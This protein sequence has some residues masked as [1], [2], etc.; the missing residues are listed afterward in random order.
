M[1][2]S[3]ITRAYGHQD[4]PDPLSNALRPVTGDRLY[5]HRPASR[6]VTSLRF[7][8]T[9]GRFPNTVLA[10]SN[11]LGWQLERDKNTFTGLRDTVRFLPEERGY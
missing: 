6:L 7:P 10:Q 4:P 3:I 5:R 11:V 9:F 1:I 2:S 8:S